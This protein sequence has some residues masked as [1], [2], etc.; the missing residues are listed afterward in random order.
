M[1]NSAV[2]TLRT[3]V[4]VSPDWFS[5]N[6]KELSEL[7]EKRNTAVFLKMTRPTRG[8]IKRARIARRDLKLAI[9]RAKSKWIEELCDN[10][11]KPNSARHGTKCFWDCINLLKKGMNKP[12]PSKQVMMTKE[13]GEKCST[14]EENANVFRTHFEKLY[15]RTPTYD[16]SVLDLLDEHPTIESTALLPQDE[17]IS[18]AI[19]HLKNKAP[20]ASG[21]T[22]QMFKSLLQ[23]D[24]CFNHLRTIIS[25][26][27]IYETYPSQFDIGKLVVLPKKGDLSLPGN[28]RGIML[29]EVAYKILA[30]IIHNRLQTLVETIDHESQCGFRQGRGCTDAVFTVRI[31]IKKRREHNLETWILFLDMVKAFDR[32]PRQLLW[33]VLAKFGVSSKLISILK[34]LHA[35]F[36]VDFEIESVSH[37]IMCT[38]GVKQGDILG[39]VLF[40]IFIAAIMITWRK[41][42]NRPLCLFHT[43]E[44]STLTGRKY[45][46]KGTEFS[47][48]DS[49][50]ADDTAVLFESRDDVATYSPL[51]ILHFGKFGMEIHVG[52]RTQPNKPSKTE[53]LFVSKPP[54]CYLDP[55]TFDGV[56]LS[57]ITLGEHTYFPIVTKFCYLGSYITRD[58]K[59]IE[60]VNN[61]LKKAGNAFGSLRKPLFSSRSISDSA[62]SAAYQK[63]ILKILL[64]GAESWSLPE[65]VFNRLRNFHHFCLRSMA[66]INRK[67]TFQH[68]ISTQQ[69][70]ERLEIKPIDH[71]VSHRQ[72]SWLGHTVRMPFKRLPRKLL[73][74]WVRN[75]RPR[76]C[77]EFTYGRGIYKALRTINVGKNSWY[78]LA[79][80]RV[81]WK[82]VLNGL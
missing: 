2:L 46:A 40:V 39:P 7:I 35:N 81:A 43:K 11:S 69:L 77:P 44:D 21:L 48:D 47:V 3:K 72:L 74:S 68:R 79:L 8:S 1:R 58:C 66:R 65:T 32:V 54:K 27:W 28:Y 4:R 36:K 67:H 51:L 15:N 63:L 42:Y 29:L 6:R 33:Q 78:D 70:L 52:D 64:H 61:R 76:G 73:S 14:P 31:A 23:H 60:D 25:D 57:D 17:E 75:R 45:N 13:N 53:V 16:E 80:D 9:Q 20:G 26:I 5:A 12:N 59:D 55:T 56:D 22:S 62:K 30:I 41:A 49:E 71:Y 34:L 19:T 38:I 82:N 50:Y 10:V 37:S 18:K 24:Q